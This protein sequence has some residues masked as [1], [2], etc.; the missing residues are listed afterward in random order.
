MVRLPVHVVPKAARSAVVGWKDGELRV[1]V[2]SAPEAGKANADLCRT[3]AAAL[4][5]PKSRVRVLRGEQSR[6]KE[7]EL[8]G[9]T[10]E[11][12]REVFGVPDSRE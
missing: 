2:S 8:Q 7:L 11:Q 3:V 1:R 12:V 10:E 9:V 6:H 4:R 5:V